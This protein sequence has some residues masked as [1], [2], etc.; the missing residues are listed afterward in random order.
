MNN[1]LSAKQTGQSPVALNL[2]NGEIKF[3]V[4]NTVTALEYLD[5]GNTA[6]WAARFDWG[7]N[8]VS[9]STVANPTCAQSLALLDGPKPDWVAEGSTHMFAKFMINDIDNDGTDDGVMKVVFEDA[10][11]S[12][13]KYAVDIQFSAECLTPLNAGGD[14]ATAGY[15]LTPTGEI[16]VAVGKFPMNYRFTDLI[17]VYISVIVT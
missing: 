14:I 10:S 11:D 17:S 8:D 4:Y 5:A 15:L 2:L 13:N 12:A 1:P 3:P 6:Q 16:D 7:N 9:I